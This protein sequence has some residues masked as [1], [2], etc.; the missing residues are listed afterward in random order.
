[1]SGIS[2]HCSWAAMRRAALG[3]NRVIECRLSS[4]LDPF[5]T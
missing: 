2:L 5:D 4:V 3:S 1:M